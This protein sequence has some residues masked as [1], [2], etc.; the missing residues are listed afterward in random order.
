MVILKVLSFSLPQ[1]SKLGVM[2]NEFITSFALSHSKRET[3]YP[4]ELL[5]QNLPLGISLKLLLKGGY[6]LHEPD[7]LLA[8]LLEY[9]ESSCIYRLVSTMVSFHPW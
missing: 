7:T 8:L 4:L 1:S 6:P 5:P 2:F 9:V 3:R